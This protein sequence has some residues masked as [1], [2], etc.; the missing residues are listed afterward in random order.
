M[1]EPAP[2]HSS[3]PPLVEL[4]E[5]DYRSFGRI[6]SVLIRHGRRALGRLYDKIAAHPLAARLLPDEASRDRAADLRF[7][8]WESIFSEGFDTEAQARSEQMAR[9]Y[10]DQGFTPDLYIASYAAVLADL[11][12]QIA[13]GPVPL[14]GSRARAQAAGTLVK[15]ALLDM[16]AALGAYFKA[17]EQARH[18][19]IASVGRGLSDM[20]TGDLRSQLDSLP[21]AYARIAEDFHNMRFNVS[22]MVLRM[23]EASEHVE[24]GAREIDMAAHD[25][26]IRTERQSLT[27]T[28]TAEVMASVAEGIAAT[29]ATAAQVNQS[30]IEID[31]EA[32]HGGKVVESAVQ[33]MDK[34]KT[35]SEEIAQITDVIEA[36]AFQTNLLAINAGVE[37]ARAGDAGR[38][39]AVVATEVRALAHRTGQSAKDIKALIG[40]STIDVRQGVDLVA[41]TGTSLD[42]IIQQLGETT[43]QAE[44]I[45]QAAQRQAG[46]IHEVTDDIRQMDLNTQQNA[47]MVEESNAASRALRD[48]AQVMGRI[49]GQFQLERRE[50]LRKDDR[51]TSQRR[52]H[53]VQSSVLHADPVFPDPATPNPIRVAN[54]R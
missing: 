20:A 4:D 23:A 22:T 34:I 31:K 35:S 26:A 39:F 10:G 52:I 49:V 47:A 50:E 27:V 36:I 46:N 9:A 44:Q 8:H 1:S 30:V 37:A 43:V 12:T 21:E 54:L 16:Q 33:A 24:T 51:K 17:E 5:A 3:H 38:G 19:V 7:N 25:L 2:A 14:P 40:K 13:Q 53:R 28:R 48:Q 45:A 6:R 32:K 18:D 15:A 29:A 42:R 41:Q 11:V